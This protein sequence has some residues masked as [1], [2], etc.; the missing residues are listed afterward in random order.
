MRLGFLIS[1]FAWVGAFD[2]CAQYE[3][4]QSVAD[5]VIDFCFESA[6]AATQG[7]GSGAARWVLREQQAQPGRKWEALRKREVPQV[8]NG[9]TKLPS[10]LADKPL[11]VGNGKV[12]EKGKRVTM[13]DTGY[14]KGGK[15][16]DGSPDGKQ[17]FQFTIGAGQ[18][19]KEWGTCWATRM[20]G[21]RCPLR[22][23]PDLG[24]GQ[25]GAG[26]VTAPDEILYFDI[27]LLAAE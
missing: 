8:N 16:F 15:K 26:G 13:H 23:P 11:V 1:I 24:C 20:V 22:I 25:A 7:L 10:G 12:P 5:E 6:S 19:I 18:V 21:G 2:L 27:Q 3:G 14:L 9:F 4:C 17:T